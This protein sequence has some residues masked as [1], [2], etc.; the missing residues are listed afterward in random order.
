MD[1]AQKIED[2]SSPSYLKVRASG[3]SLGQANWKPRSVAI[4]EGPSPRETLFSREFPIGSK[5]EVRRMIDLEL[6]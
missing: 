4:D 3:T 2:R 5:S 6:Q 1:L